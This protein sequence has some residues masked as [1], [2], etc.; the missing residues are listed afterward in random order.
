MHRN[1]LYRGKYL[2]YAWDRIYTKLTQKMRTGAYLTIIVKNIKKK[3]KSYP[4][5]YDLG[6]KLQ[7]Y[8]TL[9][10]EFFWLQDD[11]RLAP[12]GYTFVSNTFHQYCLTFR[13]K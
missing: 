1:T 7:E 13:K 6:W 4:L 3:G 12:Y 9:L 8:F 5:A 10:P 2:P 11:L